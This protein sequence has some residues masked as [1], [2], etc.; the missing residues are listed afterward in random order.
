MTNKYTGNQLLRGISVFEDLD[1]GIDPL[2]Q[3]AIGFA[4]RLIADAGETVVVSEESYQNETAEFF[5]FLEAV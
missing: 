5:H 1:N 4:G 3:Q 2:L